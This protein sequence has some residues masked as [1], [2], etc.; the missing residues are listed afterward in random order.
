MSTILCILFFKLWSY[1]S[2]LAII[3]GKLKQKLL[4]S[5]KEAGSAGERKL[6]YG[7]MSTKLIL[8]AIL[9][10]SFRSVCFFICLIGSSLKKLDRW[11]FRRL[12]LEY[13]KKRL[14]DISIS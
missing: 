12:I 10:S 9:T 1:R 3:S 8:K 11:I 6:R 13:F 2:I 7:I 4:L 5:N 14:I